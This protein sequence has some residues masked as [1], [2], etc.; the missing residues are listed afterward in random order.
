M[1]YS[2]YD[3]VKNNFDIIDDFSFFI[4]ES[5]L[6]NFSIFLHKVGPVEDR[7]DLYSGDGIIDLVLDFKAGK[8][9]SFFF[10]LSG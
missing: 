9:F 1:V 3:E 8:K 5:L 2:G 4:S 10:D 6:D 7:V